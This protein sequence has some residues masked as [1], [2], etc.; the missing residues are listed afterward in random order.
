[1]NEHVGTKFIPGAWIPLGIYSR[2]GI[3]CARSDRKSLTPLLGLRTRGFQYHLVFLYFS[4]HFDS[5]CLVFL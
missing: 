2:N 4:M 5:M 3:L 1:M